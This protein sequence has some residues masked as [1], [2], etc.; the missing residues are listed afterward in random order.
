MI[1][2]YNVGL[3]IVKGLWSSPYRQGANV[4]IIGGDP[5][6]IGTAMALDK[7]NISFVI[8]E[9]GEVFQ[10]IDS[11]TEGNK[12]T[13]FQKHGNFLRTCRLKDTSKETLLNR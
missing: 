5:A 11:Y 1:D 10:S 12:S 7:H 13:I 6:G 4:G 3:Q 9:Q 8:W 2:G